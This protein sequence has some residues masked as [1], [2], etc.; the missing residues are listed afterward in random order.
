MVDD[1]ERPAQLAVLGA[2]RIEA[3]RAGRDDRPLLH[4]VPLQGLDVAGREHLED[5]L[6]AQPAGRIAGAGLLLAE[7]READARR[8]QAG[9]HGACHLPV[10]LVEGRRAAHPV[11][12]LEAVERPVPC[13]LGDGGHAEREVPRP[14]QPPRARAAPR[15]A[16]RLHVPERAVELR[17]EAGLLED[18]VATES[19][20]LV[21]VLDED[22]ARLDAGPAGHAVPDRVVWD[23]GIHDGDRH[24]R[25]RQSIVEA[26]RLAHERAVRD[27]VQPALRVHGH[28]AD[29]HD[30][31][32]RVERLARRV[33]RAGFRAAAA[34]GAGEPIEEV[35][36]PE[37]G[38]RAHPERRALRL[39]IHGRELAARG[40]LAKIDVEEAGGHVEVLAARQVAQE[41]R[42]EQDV[43]PP[44]RGERELQDAR[45]RAA[46][47]RADGIRDDRAGA[48]AGT[49]RLERHRQELRADHAADQ[50]ED[51]E[52]AAGEGEPMRSRDQAPPGG[53]ADREEHG[54]RRHVAERRDRAPQGTAQRPA[55]DR[56]DQAPRGDV[57]R[58]DREDD[59]APEDRDVHEPGAGVPEHPRLPERVDDQARCPARDGRERVRRTCGRK[60]AQV[61][62][63][64]QGEV[65]HRAI[66]DREDEGVAGDVCVGREHRDLP[67]L[68]G[69]GSRLASR[70]IRDARGPN[71]RRDRLVR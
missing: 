38:D 50:A 70:R 18:Q 30:H 54:H 15:V 25:R 21:D 71:A 28:V 43:R 57:G 1:L 23:G 10:P 59:E 65:G 44:G 27:Q 48:V 24:G 35:L 55:D 13:H 37:V 7:D 46:Q 22:G 8:R 63:H 69:G 52:R 33:R 16:G 60:D 42:H 2:D 11:E 66:E 19:H 47:G 56:L 4:P 45:I 34:L 17:R 32:P 49:R 12:H 26:V 20:D 51:H 62:C 36:P 67:K 3:V 40:Q 6:V 64:R 53:I 29:A 41:R 31:G 5:V 9:R 61:A 58:A 39:E 68:R 14:V